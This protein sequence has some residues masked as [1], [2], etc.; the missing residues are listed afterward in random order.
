MRRDVE[1]TISCKPQALSEKFRDWN[2]NECRVYKTLHITGP[3]N[4]MLDTQENI[5][6]ETMRLENDLRNEFVKMLAEPRSMKKVALE[7]V[8]NVV[9]AKNQRATSLNEKEDDQRKEISD[10]GW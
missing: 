6:K 5:S 7:L 9:Q 3:R 8:T 1:L 10:T 2:A 4:C